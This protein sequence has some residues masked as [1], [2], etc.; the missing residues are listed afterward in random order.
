M[1]RLLKID[2]NICITTNP[3]GTFKELMNIFEEVLEELKLPKNKL[4][5][6]IQSRGSE[7][8]VIHEFDEVGFQHR[9]SVRDQSSI[10]FL[11]AQALFDYGLIRI[12]FRESWEQFVPLEKKD[13]FLELTIDKID[14]IIKDQGEFRLSIPMLYL[15]FKKV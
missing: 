7:S 6:S 11:S 10:R 15:E 9:K 12:G 4:F 3:I 14:T 13:Q 1:Y 2:G 5:N 8:S